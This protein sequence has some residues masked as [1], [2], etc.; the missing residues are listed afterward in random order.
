[1]TKL[2]K[3]KPDDEPEVEKINIRKV[4]VINYRI[5]TKINDKV[6]ISFIDKNGY[7]TFLPK[8]LI[9]FGRIIYSAS[10]SLFKNK[11]YACLTNSRKVVIFNFDLENGLMEQNKI[12]IIDDGENRFN[13]CIEIK[14]DLIVTADNKFI[15]IWEKSFDTYIN[16]K[17]YF[18]CRNK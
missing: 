11:I 16:K 7:I 17:K 10:V 13:K 2:F 15:I 4:F 5:I 14:D 6:K 1:M 12:E 8:T 18:E 3:K 9:E